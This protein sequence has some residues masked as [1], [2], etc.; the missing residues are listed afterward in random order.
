MQ[1]RNKTLNRLLTVNE[2][3]H[4]LHVHHSTVR[5][6]ENQGQLKSYR[7][8]PKG[9]IRFKKKEIFD[10]INLAQKLPDGDY[11]YLVKSGPGIPA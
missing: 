11:E 2:V 1:T 8:G 10:F 3:A 4:L 5:R 9:I 6:W 7:L